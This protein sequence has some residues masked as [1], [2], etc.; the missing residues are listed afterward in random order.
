MEKSKRDFF[1]IALVLTFII[2]VISIFLDPV[3]DE[4]DGLRPREGISIG[5]NEAIQMDKI[6]F[7]I[8]NT[9]D[10]DS[11]ELRYDMRFNNTF[12]IGKVA[13][14]FPYSVEMITNMTGWEKVNVDSGTA[15]MKKYTCNENEYCKFF[16]NEQ[17]KFEL[18][19]ELSK[20][21]TK[22][23]FK[24][25]IKVKFD[26]AEPPNADEFFRDYNMRD[27]PLQFWYDNSTIRQ[28]SIVIPRSADNIHPIPMGEP[29][30]FHNRGIDYSNNRIEWNLYKN[31]HAFFL[32]YE[33]PNERANFETSKLLITISG[34][35]FGIIIG[36]LGVALTLSREQQENFGLNY[37]IYR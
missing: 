11:I 35:V 18:K 12:T 24:H 34:I 28:V 7:Y 36:S 31:D 1:A 6:E 16:Y 25:G 5:H 2:L 14:Y 4:R 17:P 19:P 21:D 29:N 22:N 23:R 33:I 8:I 26:S 37:K 30:I 10:I 27:N 15:F 9:R 32:D 3:F 13:I 20:F